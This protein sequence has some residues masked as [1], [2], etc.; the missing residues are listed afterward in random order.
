MVM[1]MCDSLTT[2]EAI[3]GKIFIPWITG[4]KDVELPTDVPLLFNDIITKFQELF[5]F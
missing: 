2:E 5:F 3:E 1:I 4:E